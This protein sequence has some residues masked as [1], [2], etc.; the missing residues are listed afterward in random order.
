MDWISLKMRHVKAKMPIEAKKL[1]S[2][3]PPMPNPIKN[4]APNMRMAE[5]SDGL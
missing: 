4:E 2:E 3:T 1:P 5:E